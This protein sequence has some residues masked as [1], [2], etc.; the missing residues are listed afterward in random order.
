M[1]HKVVHKKYL[2]RLSG[3]GMELESFEEKGEHV[4]A[5]ILKGD[6]GQWFPIID[7]V[8]C[9]L[10]GALRPDLSW[11]EKKYGLLPCNTLAAAGNLDTRESKEQALTNK[12]FSDKWRRFRNYGME[13]PHQE[14]LFSWYCKKLGLSGIDDLKSFYRNMQLVLEVGPGSGFNTRFIAEN[15]SGEVFAADISDAAYTAFE[16]TQDLSNCHII[17]ADL[18]DLPFAEDFFD[19]IIADGVLHH[20]PDSKKAAFELYRKLRPGGKFFF[21]VYKKMGPA[22]QFCDRYLRERFSRLDPEA[23]YSA[24]KGLTELGRELSQLS[25]EINLEEGVPLLGIPPGKHKLQRLVYYNFVKCFWNDAFDFGTNNMVNFDWYHAHTAWQHTE[26]EV[27]GWIE[28]L[29]VR[30]YAFHDANPN[31]ISVLL[32]KPS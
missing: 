6:G 11:F 24:C 18:M 27:K 17:Q 16:N 31:G 25:A 12:T 4:M 3:T 14:F 15:T 13:K 19:F 26:A 32:S 20:T 1:R 2:R 9:F 30:G 7:G 5:G 10:I 29:G 21:Y 22:R 23:C 8:P 28:E